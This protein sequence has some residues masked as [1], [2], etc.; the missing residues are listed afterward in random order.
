MYQTQLVGAQPSPCCSFAR[1]FVGKIAILKA[2][3]LITISTT[4]SDL[5]QL[6]SSYSPTKHKSEVIHTKP[7]ADIPLNPG[8]LRTGSLFH[9]L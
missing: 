5:T 9:G 2:H 8:W 4:Q 7:L 1:H 6:L 3:L